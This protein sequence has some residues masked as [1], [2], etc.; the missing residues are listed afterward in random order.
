MSW[1]ITDTDSYYRTPEGILIAELLAAELSHHYETGRMRMLKDTTEQLAIGYPFPLFS[2]GCPLPPVFMLSE[3]GVLAWTRDD[4]V[5]TACIDSNSF[6]CATD[7]FE[8]VFVSHAL[9]FVADKAGFLSEI[10]RCL[11]GEGELVM[12]VPHRRSL[13]ARA[14]KTPFGQGT[15]FSRRQLKLALEQAGFDQI[16]IRHSLY[17]PP[18][19]ARLPVAMRRRL[20]VMGRIG[21]AMFGG[22]LVAVAKKRLYSPHQQPSRAL[23]HKVRQFMVRKPAGA[24]TPLRRDEFGVM[25]R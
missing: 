3:T 8:Q 9:E 20:H 2:T 16:Q 10:W 5:I 18:F 6:P 19:G 13:W 24:V 17:M 23:R 11:K 14:D 12:I 7:V 21:W 4:D 25:T 15:P 22:V 1:D